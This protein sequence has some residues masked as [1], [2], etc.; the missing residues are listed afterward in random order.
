[1]KKNDNKAIFTVKDN[2]CGIENKY[3]NRIFER[4]FRIKNNKYL[5]VQGTGL[6]L[7]IVKNICNYYNADISIKSE[8]NVGT[9]ISVAFNLYEKL[10]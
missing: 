5:Q 6:G 3:I 7:T 8:K 10:S 2:G 4:F 1:M 9:E